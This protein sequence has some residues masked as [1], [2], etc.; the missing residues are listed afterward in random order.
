MD[1]MKKDMPNRYLLLVDVGSIVISYLL[2][3]WIRYGGINHNIFH[4]GAYEV[5]FAVVL[6]VYVIIYYSY[7]TYSKVFKRGFLEEAFT[8]V[9]INLLLIA[10]ITL[11]MFLFREGASYSR[12]FIMCFFLLNIMITYIARQYY[13]VLLLALYKKSSSSYKVMVITTS[14][15]AKKVLARVHSENEWEYEI[16]YLTILD[17]DMV[18]KTIDGIPVKANLENMFE[19]A[20]LEVIDGVFVHI[21]NDHMQEINLENIVMEFQNMGI[22]VDISINTFGLKIHEKVVREMSGYHVLT[23][24]TRIFTVG[25]LILKRMV[26]ILGG[27]VGS[28]L[29]IILMIILAPIIKLESP[30]P[31]FFSQVRIG[32]N[33]RRFKIYKFR[34]MTVDAEQ[35]KTEL[36]GQNEMKGHMF[37]IKNDPRVTK[38][39]KF[40]R[41]TSLD[42]FPQFFNV[43]KGDMSLVGTRPPTEKE[44][45]QYEYRHKRRLALKAG[46]T[47][48]WQ[49]S[50]RSDIRDFEEV[51]KL[52][53]EYIDNW[54]LGMDVKI[55]IKTIGVVLFGRGAK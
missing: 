37:K 32:K 7:N 15:Q 25:Q 44:F 4:G 33:G 31:I 35:R 29:A 36:E 20:K 21:P 14:D 10:T 46:V 30:G 22:T 41:K 19:V 2:S 38:V 23:F 42:E 26:D 27:L 54:S 12:I 17:L 13:K 1:L 34:S 53:L 16:T 48:L 24:S 49:V 39:G 5:A 45:E 8:V 55:L 43:L 18:G 11:L 28:I 51:V 9:K 6:S 50:G 52:D 47:G 3:L 40:L